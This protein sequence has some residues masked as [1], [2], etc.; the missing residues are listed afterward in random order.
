MLRIL[1]LSDIHFIHCED[2]E[3]D[4]RSLET[5]FVEA[6][7]EV[8][9]SGGLNQILI[10]GDVANTG[11]ASEYEK[12]EDFL[13]RV[14]EH[15]DCDEKKTQVYVVPGNH[16]IDR[17]INKTARL[18]F[19]PI[20]LDSTKADDF[21]KNAK[22]VDLETL[23]IIYSPFKEFH[24]F[25]NAHSSADGIAEGILSE[26]PNF[27]DKGFR[28]EVKLGVLDNYIIKLHCLNS[29][30]LCDKEDVNNPRDIQVGEHKL[31]IPRFA[32]NVDTPRTTVNISM[33]HHPHAWFNNEAELI[34]AFDK[35]FKIQV[36]GHVHTQSI[37]QKEEGKSPIRLQLGSLH[38]GKGG[39][40][41]KYAP[42]YNI[43]EMDIVKGVLKM[44]VLCYSWDGEQFNK[45]ETY[46]YSMK[47]A[48]EKKVG[49][50]TNQKKEVNKIKEVVEKSD[51]IYK[52]R[53]RFFQSNHIKEIINEIDPS[54]YD[55]SK[56]EYVNAMVFF[57][58]V[59]SKQMIIDKLETALTKYN[60]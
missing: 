11:Q 47:I 48:L 59:V 26:S 54:L 13:K 12:A 52:L 51:E 38:P 22:H 36:F 17:N 3:N 5:A 2:D 44:Q 42:M 1:L 25:A 23:K 6:M 53:F 16:D 58:T 60:D 57:K 15:L 14:F 31:Y 40:P 19:R 28:K 18:A 46:S 32:Y 4:Y 33:M 8:R 43:L 35:K 30:L 41:E 55:E 29:A 24:K 50:T 56:P 20:L 21:I 9:D 49:R 39:D 7:D 27:I 45:N 37:Y 10:C 34:D